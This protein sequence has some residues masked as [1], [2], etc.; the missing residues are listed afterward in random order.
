LLDFNFEALVFATTPF[1]LIFGLTLNLEDEDVLD[2]DALVAIYLVLV[3]FS[4]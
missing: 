1:L 3:L 4:F 2:L